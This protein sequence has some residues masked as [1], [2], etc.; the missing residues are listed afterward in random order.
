MMPRDRSTD[1]CYRELHERLLLRNEQTKHIQLPDVYIV[2]DDS[3]KNVSTWMNAK[4]I[5]DV[6]KDII[7]VSISLTAGTEY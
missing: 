5:R 2:S 4:Y 7:D 3:K 1:G 6:V